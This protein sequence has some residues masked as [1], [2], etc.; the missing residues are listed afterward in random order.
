MSFT[1]NNSIFLDESNCHL[2]LLAC[3]VWAHSQTFEIKVVQNNFASKHLQIVETSHGLS[4]SS[5]LSCMIR[6]RW[7]ATQKKV[8]T[9]FS[10][11]FCCLYSY[12]P[13]VSATLCLGWE[14]KFT[15]R[16]HSSWLWNVDCYL[17]SSL[18]VFHQAQVISK[19]CMFLGADWWNMSVGVWWIEYIWMNLLIT[20][21]SRLANMPDLCPKA[22]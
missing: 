16:Q 13:W 2:R 6:T 11:S 10:E 9:W 22:K 3:C 14:K 21:K 1:L 4:I 5:C 17:N 7:A 18:M 8:G 20:F 15:V 19:I 12:L